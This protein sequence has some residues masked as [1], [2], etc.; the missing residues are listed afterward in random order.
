MKIGGSSSIGDNVMCG[1][2][3]I[4]INKVKI[5]S[6]VTLGAGTI[7]TKNINKP[8]TY[9]TAEISLES[10]DIFI[11]WWFSNLNTTNYNS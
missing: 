2:G 3:S 10:Y 6:N 7:V 1:I 4:I 8:G 11:Y 9:V 5:C